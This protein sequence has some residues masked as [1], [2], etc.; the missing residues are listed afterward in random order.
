MGGGGEKRKTN[1]MLNTQYSDARSDANR[2]GGTIYGQLP[3]AINAANNIQGSTYNTL[4]QV[5]TTGGMDPEMRA[6]Y[7]E[8]SRGGGGYG[9]GGPDMSGYNDVEAAYRKFMAGGGV[10]AGS[11]RGAMGAMRSIAGDGGWDAARRASMDEN[12]RGFKEF[13]RTGG[14]DADAMNRM[15]GGGVFDEFQRTGGFS[16]DDISN[17]R[18]RANS[19]LPAFYDAVRTGQNRMASIQGGNPAAQAAMGA[20][21]AREQAK[22]MREQSLDTELGISD[23]VR[24]GRQW[25]ATGGASAENALQ[26]LRTSNMLSGLRGA[27]DVE[28]NMLNSIAANRLRGSEGWTQGE[29]GLQNLIQQGKMFGT[30]GLEG[31]AGARASASTAGWGADD[32]MRALMALGEFESGNRLASA[33]GMTDL[34]RSAPGEVGMWL[35]ADIANRGQRSSDVL[36]VAGG[37]MQN[38]PQRDWLG[39]IG[40]LVGAAGGAMTGFGNLGFG[41]PRPTA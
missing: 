38:N 8:L 20:R 2:M 24:E 41:R 9:S 6:R 34:Y 23:R 31:V 27:S 25:G 15:R 40:G 10:D 18:T 5:A 14:L 11:V 22:G 19:T 33:G 21:L 28:S 3:G 35:N 4:N 16:D 37:R 36:G 29:L 32:E 17:I 13:G 12:I 39:T 1:Q 30:Q 26:G 7:L